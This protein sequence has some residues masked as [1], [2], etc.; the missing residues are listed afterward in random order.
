M[1]LEK[2]V[3][4]YRSYLALRKYRVVLD[5]IKPS[6]PELLHPLRQLAQFLSTPSERDNIVAD[7]DTK[8]FLIYIMFKIL[9]TYK[10]INLK[11]TLGF[12]IC[13]ILYVFCYTSS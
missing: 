13:I 8:V 1:V 6:S 9:N 5:D 11:L 7:L 10:I 12:C 4:M 2:D 3:L